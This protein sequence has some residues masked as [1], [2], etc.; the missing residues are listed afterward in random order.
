MVA[1][2]GSLS[3]SQYALYTLCRW[4]LWIPGDNIIPTFQVIRETSYSSVFKV[5]ALRKCG[6][7]VGDVPFLRGIGNEKLC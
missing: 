3:H 5:L 7:H 2:V 1:P 4:L 6:V